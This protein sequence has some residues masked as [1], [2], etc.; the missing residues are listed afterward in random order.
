MQVLSVKYSDLPVKLSRHYHDCHQ[1]LYVVSGTA[2]V[3]IDGET[4]RASG[5]SLVILSRFEEHSVQVPEGGCR[6]YTLR[7]SSEPSRGASD[8]YLLSSVLVNR[9]AQFRRVIDMGAERER[10]ERLLADMVSE[11]NGDGTMRGEM[12]DLSLKQFLIALYRVVPDVFLADTNRSTV[13]IR[14]AQMR[15]EREYGESFSLVGLA[16]EYH[17]SPSYF[18]HLFKET[19]GYAPI[20]YVMMCRLSAAKRYL[21]DT[22]LLIK[23]I[24][25]LC[26]FGDESNFSR[27]FKAKTAMTPTA[28]RQKYRKD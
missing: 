15:F 10:F 20:E 8:D 12:L 9:A 22:D 24:V 17:V 4:Y 28:F 11:Y 3:T 6:R 5:G 7:I 26:G 19:T 25:D 13:M 27:M 23:E 16:A 14:E 21:C 2:L 18:A 1:I